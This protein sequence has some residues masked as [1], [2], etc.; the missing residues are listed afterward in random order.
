MVEFFAAWCPHCKKMMPVMDELKGLMGKKL[1]VLQLDVDDAGNSEAVQHFRINS[2][3]TFILLD[4]GKQ[5]W[6]DSGERSLGELR[7]AIEG[8]V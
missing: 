2:Y 1:R 7:Q 6:R 4:H 5:L 8:H 3:P